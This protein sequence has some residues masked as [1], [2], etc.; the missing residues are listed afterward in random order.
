MKVLST[1]DQPYFEVENISL[2]DTANKL[3]KKVKK[4]VT[5]ILMK[6]RRHSVRES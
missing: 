4:K 2:L 3:M 1:T 6:A 5:N